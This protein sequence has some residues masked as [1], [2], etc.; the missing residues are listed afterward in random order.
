MK[1]DSDVQQAATELNDKMERLKQV[2]DGHITMEGEAARLHQALLR[3]E[4]ADAMRLMEILQ[5]HDEACT[6]ALEDAKC[7]VERKLTERIHCE[8]QAMRELNNAQLQELS[9]EHAHHL[10]E[11]VRL[12]ECTDREKMENF[13]ARERSNTREMTQV[14]LLEER[15]AYLDTL[16]RLELDVEV[17]AR[18]LSHDRCALYQP[19][20]VHAPLGYSLFVSS[21]DTSELVMQYSRWR[22]RH[23][24]S[25]GREFVIKQ[26]SSRVSWIA[27]EMNVST[28]CH[29]PLLETRHRLSLQC[30]SCR[31]ATV[32]LKLY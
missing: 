12:A 26:V 32:Q 28:K 13:I 20:Y 31:Y 16:K 4:Q 10:C 25:M 23:A 27:S 5:R 1:A 22:P 3:Q 9:D 6:A 18:V 21:V 19:C 24:R 15:M 8:Q 14:A 7:T 29:M 17:L 30:R 2:L 11:V